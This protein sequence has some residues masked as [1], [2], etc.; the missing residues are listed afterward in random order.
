MN[1]LLLKHAGTIG[2]G[3]GIISGLFIRL[4]MAH[5][6]LNLFLN[7]WFPLFVQQQRWL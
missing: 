1:S 4:L 3:V 7:P 5:G 2:I 6:N